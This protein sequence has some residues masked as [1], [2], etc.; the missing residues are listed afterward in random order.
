MLDFKKSWIGQ[1]ALRDYEMSKDKE[2]LEESKDLYKS[3]YE[4]AVKE[5]LEAIDKIHSIHNFTLDNHE[6]K[7]MAEKL[8]DTFVSA[9]LNDEI[10][11]RRNR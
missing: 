3:Y 4:D 8:A 9:K 5:F 7:F 10:M 11:S 2:W 1:D 6:Y